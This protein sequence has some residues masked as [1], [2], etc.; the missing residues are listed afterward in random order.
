MAIYTNYARYLK[1]KWFKEYLSAADV[2][3]T[4]MVFGIGNPYWDAV[5]E[6][7][8]Q[9]MPVAPYNT[10]T[11]TE[12][13][14][15]AD[16]QFYDNTVQQYMLSL[17]AAPGESNP[18]QTVTDGV[19]T[20][21]LIQHTGNFVPA[22]PCIW[23]Y[24]GGG[25]RNLFTSAG[26]PLN[27]ITQNTY[28]NYYIRNNT[29]Y[30]VDSGTSESIDSIS[31][32]TNQELCYY[33]ELCMRGKALNLNVSAAPGYSL[34]AFQLKTPVGLL[35]AVR[36]SIE[37]VKDAGPN[38][39]WI[40]GTSEYFWYGDRYWQIVKDSD[41][42]DDNIKSDTKLPHHLMF[43]SMVSPRDLCSELDLDQ[44][45]V[46]RQIAIY[47]RKRTSGR[48]PRFYRVEENVF[49]F[50]QYSE[51]ELGD[52][53]ANPSVLQVEIPAT[54]RK[55]TLLNF[56]LPHLASGASDKTWPEGEFKFV[57]HDYIRGANR[58]A[59]SSDRFGYV[60]GF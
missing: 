30:N 13:T 3:D 27:A 16:N 39:E 37:F 11:L 31:S 35:G 15:T 19:A 51:A 5:N 49:N 17:S 43:L 18:L 4:Y 56:T 45:L 34:G 26:A 42:K 44:N 32:L 9:S 33:S 38:G 6:E 12:P 53:F 57:L 46:P 22:F 47:T 24:N 7:S 1:A 50:G 40:E 28:Q 10:T 21:G 60:V 2:G 52:A 36:C 14:S 55:G 54:D 8:M 25:D 48:G 59:H 23:S 58:N 20:S 29:L 41:A